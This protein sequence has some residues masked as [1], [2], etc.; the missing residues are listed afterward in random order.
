MTVQTRIA[1]VAVPFHSRFIGILIQSLANS[2]IL[3][4][5]PYTY[6]ANDADDDASQSQL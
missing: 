5:V 1:G 6:M 2:G 4:E 3:F